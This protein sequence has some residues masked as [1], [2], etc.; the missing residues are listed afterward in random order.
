MKKRLIRSI[1]KKIY[2]A[3][4]FR[5]IE[6]TADSISFS[7]SD[8]VIFS[9]QFNRAF[10]FTSGLYRAGYIIEGEYYGL[11]YES[12]YQ[13]PGMIQTAKFRPIYEQQTDNPDFI[14]R[15]SLYIT[16]N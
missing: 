4:F 14:L 11:T 5:I 2:K 16:Q 3:G 15:Q 13:R 8:G 7:N 9:F 1:V 10:S 6:V 12:E